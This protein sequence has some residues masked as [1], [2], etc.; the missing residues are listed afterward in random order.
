MLVGRPIDGREG[1]AGC[2]VTKPLRELRAAVAPLVGNVGGLA[3][4]VAFEEA[5]PPGRLPPFSSS[6][7][8]GKGS[9]TVLFRAQGR[10][11]FPLLV[12]ALSQFSQGCIDAG[13][14]PRQRLRAT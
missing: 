2:T 13:L 3:G 1:H 4:D 5:S 9:E 6:F 11:P 14:G 7:C 8:L 10:Q 12:L